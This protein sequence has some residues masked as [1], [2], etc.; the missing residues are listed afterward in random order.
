MYT[1]DDLWDNKLYQAQLKTFGCFAASYADIIAAQYFIKPL[2]RLYCS[3]LKE[4]N[5][6]KPVFQNRGFFVEHSSK[7]I[8]FKKTS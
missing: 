6:W 8:V 4:F 7:K 2:A 1:T 5:T 3:T